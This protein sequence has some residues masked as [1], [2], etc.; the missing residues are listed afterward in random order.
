MKRFLPLVGMTTIFKRKGIGIRQMVGVDGI[1]RAI[2]LIPIPPKKIKLSF[3]S[4]ARNLLK[5]R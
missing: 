2:C 3:R 4:E 5:R 1:V